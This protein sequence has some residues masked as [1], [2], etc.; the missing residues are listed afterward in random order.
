MR[1]RLVRTGNIIDAQA[2]CR[3]FQPADQSAARRLRVFLDGGMYL[4]LGVE[5]E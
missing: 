4:H 5:S 2:F 1:C 3:I